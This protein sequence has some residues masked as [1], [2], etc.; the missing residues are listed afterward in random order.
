MTQEQTIALI[1]AATPFIV[2]LAG[3][4]FKWLVAKLPQNTQPIIMQLIQ[5]GVHAAEQIGEGQTGAAKK[6]IAEDFINTSL[7]A[8]KIHANPAFVDAA[9]EAMVF[10]LN[11]QQ[12]PIVT[13]IDT[14]ANNG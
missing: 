3:V 14:S 10:S 7:T 8:L 1:A 11:Q 9:I 13:P 5:I 12:I 6:K 4:L 2:S